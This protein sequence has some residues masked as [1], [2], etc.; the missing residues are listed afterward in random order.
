MRAAPLACIAAQTDPGLIAN[1]LPLLTVAD[2]ALLGH[3]AL[4]N[5][6][7]RLVSDG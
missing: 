4:A 7:H 1:H 2:G 3:V 6:M 5:D